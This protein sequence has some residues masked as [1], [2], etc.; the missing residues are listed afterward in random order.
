MIRG[1]CLW[2]HGALVVRRARSTGW[3]T[4]HCGMCR[5]AHGAPFATY[6]IGSVKRNSASTRARMPSP[7]LRVLA[8]VRPWILLGL[9]LRRAVTRCTEPAKSASRSVR[10]TT[11]RACALH[12]HIYVKWKAPWHRITDSL[13]Q[14]QA[15][16]SGGDPQRRSPR[17]AAIHRRRAARK[18]S[19]LRA[20]PTRSP[21]RSGSVHNCPLLALPQGPRGGAY[22]QR[23]QRDGTTCATFAAKTRS[24]P[25][26]L[27]KRG[28]S[29]RP[30][31][32]PAAPG[33]PRL[34]PGARRRR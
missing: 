32:R 16:E 30:S 9:R 2:P 26:G 20:S 23:L 33:M 10:S 27:R 14:H 34:D 13:P 21:D 15:L 8:R 12:G 19:V 22:L 24:G 28:T 31:A 3:R 7:V 5:K 1:S 18:L 29:A 6:A 25:T 17:F 4:V 11:I